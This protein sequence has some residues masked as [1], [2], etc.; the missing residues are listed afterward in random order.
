MTEAANYLIDLFFTLASYIFMARFL[1]QALQANFYNPVSQGLVKMTDPVLKPARYV[2]PSIRNI[3][4]ASFAF[5][6][7]AVGLKL[8]FLVTMPLGIA[9]LIGYSAMQTLLLMIGVLQFCIFAVFIISLLS[10]LGFVSH[11]NPH[12]II[13]LLYELTEP[14]MAPIRKLLP[15]MGGLDFSLMIVWI[16]LHVLSLLLQD[17]FS[18]LIGALG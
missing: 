12:P 9:A 14:L 5:A 1:L 10:L 13:M 8:F 7:L 15:P 16:G 18:W 11:N 17:G 4:T 6:W 2:L 3:D